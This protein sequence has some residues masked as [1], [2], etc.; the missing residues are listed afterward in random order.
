VSVAGGEEMKIGRDG[1]SGLDLSVC[2]AVRCDM[3][4]S[5]PN[6]PLRDEWEWRVELLLSEQV[7]VQVH[8]ESPQRESIY[9]E[10]I[11]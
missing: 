4:Q 5:S 7:I 3:V 1:V 2:R 10:S 9:D 8:C 11:E 6:H